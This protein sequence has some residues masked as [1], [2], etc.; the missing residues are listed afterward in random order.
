MGPNIPTSVQMMIPIVDVKLVLFSV[1]LKACVRDP[2]SA[3]VNL[4]STSR[5]AALKS[6]VL[7]CCPTCRYLSENLVRSSIGCNSSLLFISPT[8]FQVTYNTYIH[9]NVFSLLPTYSCLF[10]LARSFRLGSRFG[11]GGGVIQIAQQNRK[12]NAVSLLVFTVGKG[13]LQTV[14]ES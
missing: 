11:T 6:N 2:I 8:P 9:P 10:Y 5:R 3:L 7:P 4:S 13:H 14:R 1:K 12:I